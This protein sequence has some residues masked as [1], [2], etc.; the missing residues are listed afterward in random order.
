M[1]PKSHGNSWRAV[2]DFASL[3]SKSCHFV[4]QYTQKY[5]HGVNFFNIKS[6]ATK[7]F[8]YLNNTND[9]P[10]VSRDEVAITVFGHLFMPVIFPWL[11]KLSIS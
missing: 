11:P 8:F 9:Y 2:Q 10:L 1:T 7:Y 3:N 5:L 6:W 4:V